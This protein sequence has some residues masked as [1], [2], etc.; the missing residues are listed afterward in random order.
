MGASDAD[1]A[2]GAMLA[3]GQNA[4][5]SARRFD[6]G[7]QEFLARIS[8]GAVKGAGPQR[9]QFPPGNWFDDRDVETEQGPDNEAPADEWAGNR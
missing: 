4:K 7:S 3:W 8:Q 9:L 6:K 5:M 1:Q 2:P